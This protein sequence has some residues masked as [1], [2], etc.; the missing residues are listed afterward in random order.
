MKKASRNTQS[1]RE[2]KYVAVIRLKESTGYIYKPYL[3]GA[4][5]I[6][7]SNKIRYSFYET[8]LDLT[9]RYIAVQDAEWQHAG[10]D[11]RVGGDT[12]ETS[13]VVR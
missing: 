7:L 4:E 5:S 8:I 11:C 3:S 12:D 6:S 10:A 1:C 2:C 13:T 9:A